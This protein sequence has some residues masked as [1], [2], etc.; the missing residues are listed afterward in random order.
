MSKED[1]ETNGGVTY[2]FSQVRR[3][4]L[5]IY[6]G[7]IIV[8]ALI[9]GAVLLYLNYNNNKLRTTSVETEGSNVVSL[10][11]MP[12]LSVGLTGSYDQNAPIC[13][14]Y[15]NTKSYG[16]GSSRPV[17]GKC[18]LNDIKFE[19]KQTYDVFSH[20]DGSIG[21]DQEIKIVVQ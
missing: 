5:L 7:I 21:K 13:H 9:I 4:H 12:T 16:L 2:N 3:K 6:I 15:L 18:V 1:K 11:S 14:W 19:N 17:D 20:V 10:G 8:L